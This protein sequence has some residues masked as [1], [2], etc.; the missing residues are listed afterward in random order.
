MSSSLQ[1]LPTQP[2]AVLLAIYPITLLLGSLYS[3]IS[4][5]ANPTAQST[6]RH[7]DPNVS[8]SPVNYFARKN[9]AF[10]VYFV[11]IGWIWTTLAFLSLLSTQRAFTH[12]FS[13][14][15]SRLRRAAQACARYTLITVAWILM[16][17]WFFGAPIID[18]GFTT[19][20]GKCQNLRPA[21]P[22]NPIS[23]LGSILT[24]TA[25]KAA[26]GAWNG[27]HDISGHVFMLVLASAFLVFELLG[28]LRL[29]CEAEETKDRNEA[30]QPTEQTRN[31]R[32]SKWARN[33]VWTVAGLSW[34]MLF[35]TAIWF[36]TWL[37]KVSGLAIALSTIY[38]IYIL[39]QT[40][41][42][43]RNIIGIP[44]T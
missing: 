7:S 22:G 18:R 4:P 43:W 26:G 27:G 20:G 8:Q 14:P 40:T 29:R 1:S 39:P 25:C 3:F 34:W 2:P 41:P 30:S 28:S 37:E 9:N 35:M 42:S 12:K 6:A 17:Q 32:T 19:T 15:E 23:E 38:C 33:F 21:V 24:G 36:H 16:T 5:T 13:S 31:E 44:G 11:K 10:N